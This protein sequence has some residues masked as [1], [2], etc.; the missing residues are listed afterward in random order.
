MRDAESGEYSGNATLTVRVLHIGSMVKI[1]QILVL[2]DQI[3]IP[4]K[5]KK[6][7]RRPRN[8]G[9]MGHMWPP[10]IGGILGWAYGLPGI[11]P[12]SSMA[13]PVN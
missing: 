11:A 7:F 4:S 10:R 1:L 12:Q 6:S 5:K 9:M 13:E 2:I 3:N 8:A